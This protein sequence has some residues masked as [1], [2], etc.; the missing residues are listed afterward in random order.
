MYRQ[1]AEQ[2][3]RRIASGQWP[4]GFR[5]PA[6]RKL[7][8]E[9]GVN[10]STLA[11]ALAELTADG[12][13]AGRVG[14][15]TVVANDSWSLLNNPP[16]P[17]WRHYAAVGAQKPN[18]PT[19]QSINR[20]EFRNGVVRLGT[21]EL[22]P[23]LMPQAAMARCLEQLSRKLPA[24]GY[25]QPNGS[26]ALRLA[27]SRRLKKQGILAT[28]DSILIVSGALQALQ[29][30][31][32]GLLPPGAEILLERPSYLSSLT[33]F[34]TQFAR[35]TAL[36]LD[37]EGLSVTAL[38]RRQI[39]QPA[40][41]LYTIPCFH[42][43][44][45]ITM[46]K[47]RRQDVIE[48]CRRQRL[49]ILEDDVYRELWLDAPPPAP[50]KAADTN[51]LVLH[52]C[53]LSKSLSP[54]LRIG[55]LVGPEPVINRLADLKMQFDYGASSISQSIAEWWLSGDEYDNHL[56]ALRDRLRLRRA[57]ALAALQR[58]FSAIA[59]WNMPDG[60]FYIWLTLKQPL[61]LPR[62]FQ[63]A[64]QQGLLLNP[65]YLYDGAADRQLRI[66]Y[67]YATEQELTDAL[68]T[69][70]QLI[71]KENKNSIK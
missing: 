53:S 62:L 5:L 34:Q 21:G 1:I 13:L 54:G 46:S 28:P 30:I 68:C 39:A 45:G 50:L 25:E 58:H 47:R 38:E 10:R 27:I 14:S 51:G 55:W 15:G 61:S 44:T 18:L 26:A 48:L 23:E 24:L 36:P 56:A 63:T 17:D 41:L 49:P 52:L 66:S 59:D 71:E 67:S 69:L 57:A 40:D 11:Q 35:L 12:L 37:E 65:G 20:N 19:I 42:N 4:A 29:L 31:S 6:Q 64:L 2:C 9:L 43:P 32:T 8:A 70:A 22:S 60:G 33:L 16:P 7:A 3:R